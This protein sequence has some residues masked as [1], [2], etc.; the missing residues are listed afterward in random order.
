MTIMILNF[1]CSFYFLNYELIVF[2]FLSK[3][4]PSCF[5]FINGNEA[6]GEAI[7]YSVTVLIYFLRLYKY[8]IYPY[9][10]LYA[11]FFCLDR[12]VIAAEIQVYCEKVDTIKKYCR[13]RQT[14]DQ[15]NFEFGG[16]WMEC[17]I[18]K[19]NNH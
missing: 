19:M 12:I 15:Q 11:F 9:L 7:P 8:N 4:P 6:R 2:L 5:K 16:W 14:H 10:S 1:D 17:N 13:S 18:S 3:F